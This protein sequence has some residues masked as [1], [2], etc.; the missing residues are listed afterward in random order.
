MFVLLFEIFN[1]GATV[2][3]QDPGGLSRR[4]KKKTERVIDATGANMV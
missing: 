1:A 4:F 2:P 3:V